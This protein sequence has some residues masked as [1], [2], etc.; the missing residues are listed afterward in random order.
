MDGRMDGWMGG[1]MDGWRAGRMGVGRRAGRMVGRVYVGRASVTESGMKRPPELP[2]RD[3]P[4][5][6]S[7][8]LRNLLAEAN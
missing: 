3:C 5:Q 6:Q 1:R 4:R 8:D 7:S 2:H